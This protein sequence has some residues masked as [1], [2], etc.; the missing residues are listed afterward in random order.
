[1]GNLN[2]RYILSF[3]VLLLIEI[4]IAA[5]V[6]DRFIRP[7]IGDVLVVLLI[8]CFLRISLPPYR[9]LP[10]G[11]FLF[12]ALVEVAQKF[13]FVH[14]LGLGD[15]RILSIALGS[16]FDWA[17]IICYACGGYIIF[18][19]QRYARSHIHPRKIK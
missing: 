19:W 12:A 9:Y 1:M 17:D 4:F 16:T 10:A 3:L 11:V 15:N 5:C 8:Y 2:K 13:D 7:Y 6:H 18:V 14:V